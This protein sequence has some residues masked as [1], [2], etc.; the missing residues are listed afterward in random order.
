MKIPNPFKGTENTDQFEIPGYPDGGPYIGESLW[1]YHH[2]KWDELHGEIKRRAVRL[3]QAELTPGN[4]REWRGEIENDPE[5]W[6]AKHHMFAGMSFRNLLRHEIPDKE[7][8]T[9][10]W[11]DYYCAALEAATGTYQ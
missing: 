1:D 9:G 8:P 10:N 6:G 2:R 5:H 4:L 11:D 7:L 3:L